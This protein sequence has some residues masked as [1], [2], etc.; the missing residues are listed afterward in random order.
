MAELLPT[1]GDS[2]AQAREA[3]RYRLIVELAQ[4]GIWVVDAEGRT[5]YA[6]PQLAHMLGYTVTEMHGLS[7]FDCIFPEDTAAL[8]AAR[9]RRKA[10]AREVYEFRYKRRDGSELWARV[11]TNVLHDDRGRFVGALGILTD[12]TERRR[13]ERNNAFLADVARQVTSLSTPEDILN[14]AW[15]NLTKYFDASCLT[16]A[17]VD[18][19]ANLIFSIHDPMAPEDADVHGVQRLSELASEEF[20]DELR[21]ERV[22]AID[23]LAT[24]PRT[25]ARAQAFLRWNVRSQVLVPFVQQGRLTYIVGLHRP[26]PSC[27]RADETHLL[28]ELATCIMLHHEHARSDV[29]MKNAMELL[30]EKVAE[31]T[32]ELSHEVT[33]R[34]AAEERTRA[35]MRRLL[36]AQENERRSIARELHDN[37]GQQLTALHL[38]LEALSRAVDGHPRAEAQLEDIQAYLQQFDRDLDVFT[39]HLRPA[40]LYHLGLVPS[41]SDFIADWSRTTGTAAD[42]DVI[43]LDG[44]RLEPDLETNLYRIAQEAL[45]NI[46]KHA[47]A[48]RVSVLLQR[49]DDRIVLSIEDDGR[50]FDPQHVS[51]TS[52][53]Q[54]MGLTGMQERATLFRGRVA[55]DSAPG[56]G[57]SIV[58][59]MPAVFR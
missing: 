8:L 23:D 4:E 11:S 9:E 32:R 50:G 6:N 46:R 42:F 35:L 58:V 15:T 39:A 48:S 59:T 10:H 19:S 14:A 36:T 55:I 57:T 25:A 21:R 38:K 51:A 45:T 1:P 37:L 26:R 3:E 13:R 28:R 17:E 5:E 40:A 33:E 43:G 30:E 27:W 47:K 34:R 54:G 12:I 41:L 31:R 22:V 52:G 29:A 56:Q 20:L 16:L 44:R 53:G 24:D 7:V 49:R 2:T 18:E